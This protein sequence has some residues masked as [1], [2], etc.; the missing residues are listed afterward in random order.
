MMLRQALKQHNQVNCECGLC[1]FKKDKFFIRITRTA[2]QQGGQVF[3][4]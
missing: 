4:F 1:V 3:E 2:A